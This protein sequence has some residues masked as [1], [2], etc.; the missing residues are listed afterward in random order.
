MK[1]RAVNSPQRI[2]PGLVYVP[3]S[4]P[5]RSPIMILGEAP[6]AQEE[7]AAR[8]GDPNCIMIGPTGWEA[9]KL[10]KRASKDLYSIHSFYKTNVEKYRPPNNDLRQL[11]QIGVTPFQN[12]DIVME[13]ARAVGAKLILGFGGHAL[14]ALTGKK[15]IHKWRG[16]ILEN[17]FTKL[18]KVVCTFHPA[19]LFPRKGQKGGNSYKV[20]HWMVH[21]IARAIEESAYDELRLP[22]REIEICQSADHLRRFLRQYAHEKRWSL[23]TESI[24]GI[25]TCLGLAASKSHGMSVPLFNVDSS[26][27]LSDLDYAEIYEI[28][29]Q[30]LDDP[31]ILIIGQNWK[32]DED[33]LETIYSFRI[34]ARLW[35]DTATASHN[36][37]P[38]FPKR[39]EFITSIFTREPYYKD[40]LKEFD[41]TKQR[42]VDILKYNVKDVCVPWEIAVEKFEPE[43]RERGLWDMYQ[44]FIIPQHYFYKELER[45]GLPVDHERR[46]ELWR[47]WNAKSVEIQEE[48]DE[49]A[50]RHININSSVKDVPWF[51]DHLGFPPRGGYDEDTC[52]Q[53]LGNHAKTFAQRR[54]IGLLLDGRKIKRFKSAYIAAKPDYDDRMRTVVNQN[55]TETF[56]TADTIL[57]NKG[58]RPHPIGLPFKTLS[59]H[60]EIGP[61]LREEFPVD[62]PGSFG[63]EEGWE[64]LEC[65]QSQAEARV[66]AHLSDD[67]ELLE[68]FDTTDVH[69]MTAGWFFYKEPSDV[70]DDERFIGKQGRH[71]G[72]LGAGKNRYMLTIN[73]EARRFGI[74]RVNADGTKGE[75]VTVSEKECAGFHAVFHAKSPRIRGVYHPAV[76]KALKDN[77]MILTSPFGRQRQFTDRYDQKLEREAYS[78]IPQA[79]VTDA[80]KRAG[81]F[82]AGERWKRDLA[83]RFC[84]E[85]HDSLTALTRPSQR[86][87]VAALFKEA[88]EMPIDFERCS[89]QK[90]PLV[91]PCEIKIGVKNLRF[92]EKYKP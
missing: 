45:T 31:T 64:Y 54:G 78:T 20:S 88:F 36:L 70:S 2:N 77:N 87:E 4:G 85:S 73:T 28:L 59:K 92:M 17:Q 57:S 8:K 38:E 84:I 6:G 53:L 44:E 18:P 32:H 27:N 75:I 34:R 48:I 79:T 72:N 13:E 40:E 51:M 50:G 29:G 46:L 9:D 42:Y 63:S 12:M 33:K 86:K 15:G 67:A 26:I 7:D 1:T 39:L 23:D 81:L 41:S 35:M 5:S 56:R 30:F 66:V 68:L 74:R 65:D 21:D 76:I 60:G 10:I 90:G 19:S 91:I 37:Y 47:K 16:S 71:M 43:L 82:I 11:H 55:G 83:V 24:R 61:E 52:V 14:Q 69:R 25:P 58:T 80:T 89:I 49:I 22:V 3:G 62:P